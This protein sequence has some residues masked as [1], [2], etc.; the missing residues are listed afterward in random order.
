[1]Y[2]SVYD[3]CI[4]PSMI[5]VQIGSFPG[6]NATRLRIYLRKYWRTVSEDEG[7]TMADTP[8][9]AKAKQTTLSTA[10]QERQCLRKCAP[11]PPPSAL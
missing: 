11:P 7:C 2:L 4:R 10:A 6:N 8:V 5:R 3:P 9:E 1:M